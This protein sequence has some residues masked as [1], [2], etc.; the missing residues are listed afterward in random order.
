M[1]ATAVTLNDLEDHSSVAGLFKCNLSNICA[2]FHTI[3]T[4]SVLARFLCISRASC[5]TR[6]RLRL[7]GRRSVHR[8]VASELAERSRLRAEQCEETR[9][10][11]WTP[12]ALSANVLL[13]TD[14][15]CCCLKTGLHRAVLRRA[16]GESGR[17]GFAEEA[18]YCQA[19]VALPVTGRPTCFSWT[20]HRRT[21]LARCFSCCSRRHYNLSPLIDW[22]TDSHLFIASKHDNL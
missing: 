7:L 13:V 9:H 20:A 1:A 5:R 17:R 8:S 4:D 21:V 6:C 14:G 11:S 18:E 3:S 19:C 2:A 12:A 15:V 22:L 16:G 10:R